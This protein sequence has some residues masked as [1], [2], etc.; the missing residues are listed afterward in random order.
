VGGLVALIFQIRCL[1]QHGFSMWPGDLK[2]SYVVR[3]ILRLMGPTILSS[4]LYQFTVFFTTFLASML[5]EG[6]VS[7]LYYADRVFQFPLGVFSLALATAILPTL[8]RLSAEKKHEALAR[9][10]AQTID[11]VSFI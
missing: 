10:L 1:A 2:N 11:W 7:W 8:S 4:S 5:A 6:S 9:Q 3:R